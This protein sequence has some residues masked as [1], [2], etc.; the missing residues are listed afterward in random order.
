MLP[1]FVFYLFNTPSVREQIKSSATGATVRHT[2]PSRIYDVDILLPTLPI[3]RRI[4]GILSTYDELIEK[5]Q[6]RIKILELMTSILYQLSVQG[7]GTSE[8]SAN[9]FQP[10][11][12][13][14]LLTLEYGK[15]LTKEN[16]YG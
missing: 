15:S 6:R 14:S 12:V 3:Q 1:G 16:K 5:S 13:G 8:K 11:S 2:A 10:V 4:A 9:T 7:L